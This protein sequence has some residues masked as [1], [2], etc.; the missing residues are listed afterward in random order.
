LH[1]CWPYPNITWSHHWCFRQYSYYGT[2][3]TTHSVS[4]LR[5]FGTIVDNTPCSFGGIQH[6]QNLDGYI[7]PLSLRSGL[8]YMDMSPSTPT[9]LGS[10]PDVFLKSDT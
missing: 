4:Q 1:C 7:I 10:Y 3:N 9:E 6:L 2:G 5:E 8:P